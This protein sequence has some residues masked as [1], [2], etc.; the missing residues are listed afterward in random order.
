MLKNLL[1]HIPSERLLRPVVDSAISL[2]V[3][4]AAHLRAISVGY[5]TTSV[6]IPRRRWRRGGRRGL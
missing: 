3:S 1:V 6:G 5:E 4:H 2:A